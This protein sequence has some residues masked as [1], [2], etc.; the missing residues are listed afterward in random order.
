NGI[1]IKYGVDENGNTIVQRFAFASLSSEVLH[2]FLADPRLLA[3]KGFIGEDCR[4]G[5]YEKDGLVISHY[6]NVDESQLTKLGWHT[7]GMRDLFAGFRLDP[8]IN[9]G[10]SLDDSPKEKGGLRIL[11]G[12]HKQNIYDFFFRKK[13]FIDNRDDKNEFAVETKAG[14]LTVHHGRVWHRAAL[15]TVKGVASKRRMFYFPI[16][17]GKFKPK[18]EKSKTPIYHHFQR[19]VR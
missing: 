10:I 19:V 1:P 8:M 15:A 14:D 7:D 2:E 4:I 3:L 13:H 16:I 9:I 5:E 11:P 18:S 6:V 12:S 17:A